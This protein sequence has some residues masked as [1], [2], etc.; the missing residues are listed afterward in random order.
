MEAGYLTRA[1]R[2]N[3]SLPTAWRVAQSGVV[4]PKW[5]RRSR[6]A[7][8]GEAGTWTREIL[9]QN[10]FAAHR[11]SKTGEICQIAGHVSAARN[12]VCLV[13]IRHDLERS[14]PGLAP[15]LAAQVQ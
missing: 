15:M 4:R 1:H 14:A 8:V 6:G 10:W 13:L 11:T 7:D 5:L 9:D 12:S 2:V 3:I